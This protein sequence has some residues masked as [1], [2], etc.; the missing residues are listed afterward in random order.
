MFYSPT[1]AD[2]LVITKIFSGTIEALNHLPS[3]LRDFQ[4][5]TSSHAV[6]DFESKLKDFDSTQEKD[7]KVKA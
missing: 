3:E 6:S 5:L 7:T 2:K 1:A 4:D